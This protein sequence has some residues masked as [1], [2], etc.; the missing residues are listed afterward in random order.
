MR[1]THKMPVNLKC[2][3][4]VRVSKLSLDDF[5]SSS[6]VEQERGMRVTLDQLDELVA[7]MR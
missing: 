4:S 1:V 6:R 5:W 3:A 2:S 7:S